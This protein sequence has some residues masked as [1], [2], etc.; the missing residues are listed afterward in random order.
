MGAV[1]G[2]GGMRQLFVF[3]AVLLKKEADRSNSVKQMLGY[4]IATDG[5]DAVVGRYVQQILEEN[6]GYMLAGK[7]VVMEI[8]RD[9]L[10]EMDEPA[11]GGAA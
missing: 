3:S 7:V 9:E 8:T 1:A 4:N 5:E 11:A 6:P 2:D 10:R